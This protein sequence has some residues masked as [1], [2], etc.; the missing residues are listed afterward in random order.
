MGLFRKKRQ[1]PS[2]VGGC[3]FTLAGD[4]SISANQQHHRGEDPATIAAVV[5]LTY[6]L[7]TIQRAKRTGGDSAA[8][9]RLDLLTQTR[10]AEELNDRL[11]PRGLIPVAMPSM[12]PPGGAGARTLVWRWP[13]NAITAAWSDDDEL[14]SNELMLRGFAGLWVIADRHGTGQLVWHALRALPEHPL[15]EPIVA[16]ELVA[17]PMRLLE[18]GRRAL[19]GGDTHV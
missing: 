2:L 19:N 17:H 5:S 8:N 10:D 7:W 18:A 6:G 15:S 4:G 14:D 16:E 11:N 1:G 13:E 3:S 9:T 12:L